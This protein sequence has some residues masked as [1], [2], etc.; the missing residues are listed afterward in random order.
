VYVVYLNVG[1][2]ES[3]KRFVLNFTEL[4]QHLVVGVVTLTCCL[5]FRIVLKVS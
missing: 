3:N 4:H 2:H 5:W 1:Y